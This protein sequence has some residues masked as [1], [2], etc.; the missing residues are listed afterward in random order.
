MKMSG[1]IGITVLGDYLPHLRLKR[2]AAV[3]ANARAQ[4]PQRPSAMIVDRNEES[5]PATLSPFTDPVR[6]L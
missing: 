4:N 2:S 5:R 1:S 3:P 6:K